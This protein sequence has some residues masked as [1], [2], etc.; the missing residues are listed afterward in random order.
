MA[1]PKEPRTVPER[2][3]KTGDTKSSQNPDVDADQYI[4]SV[5]EFPQQFIRL[6][7]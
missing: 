5:P 6:A 3:P 7:A 4:R 1:D 2:N